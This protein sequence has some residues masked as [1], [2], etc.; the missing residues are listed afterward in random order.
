M[1]EQAFRFAF[2]DQSEDRDVADWGGDE[3]FRRMPRRRAPEAARRAG[4]PGREPP[5]A[6]RPRGTQPAGRRLELVEPRGER[7]A[8]PVVARVAA[9]DQPAL[10]L[11]AGPAPAE[12]AGPAPAEAAVQ[13]PAGWAPVERDAGG[14]RTTVITG[15]PDDRHVPR[16]RPLPAAAATRRRRPQAPADWLVARPER[17]VAWAFVLGLL[18]ILIAI[19]TADAA[20]L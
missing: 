2:Y 7:T 3:L 16:P 13:I 12:A 8:A 14:R 19:S 15:H 6:G 11:V 1:P 20:T 4:A 18:L 5:G 17:I 10:A 9:V